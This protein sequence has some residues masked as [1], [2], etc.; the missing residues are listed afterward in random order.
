LSAESTK[1]SRELDSDVDSLQSNS[2]RKVSSLQKQ[3]SR[4]KRNIEPAFDSDAD[5]DELPAENDDYVFSQVSSDPDFNGI[6]LERQEYDSLVNVGSDSETDRD[7]EP[8]SSFLKRLERTQTAIL[9]KRAERRTPLAIQRAQ[10]RSLL[11]SGVIDPLSNMREHWESYVDNI[12]KDF[13]KSKEARLELSDRVTRGTAAYQ[14]L[15]LTQLNNGDMRKIYN[16]SWKSKADLGQ[17]LGTYHQ[18]RIVVGQYA[19]F[20]VAAKLCSAHDLY[21]KGALCD[22]LC[23]LP[24][25]QAFIRYFEIRSAAGTVMNKAFHLIRLC[26]FAESHFSESGRSEKKGNIVS[27]MTYLQTVAKAFKTESRRQAS[28][29]K[30]SDMRV[31]SGMYLTENDITLYANNA[32]DIL[33]D[34][35]ESCRSVYAEKGAEGVTGMMT[36]TNKM[37][38][39][40]CINFLSALTLHGGGQRPQVYT[41]LEA[42]SKMDFVDMRESVKS[43]GVFSIRVSFEKRVRCVDLPQVLFLMRRTPVAGVFCFTPNQALRWSHDK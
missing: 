38:N 28:I 27:V 26:K 16:I 37:L 7:D 6:Q 20:S 34:M 1:H 8:K 36:S 22:I 17:P 3:Q 23:N 35:L 10:R 31:G 9:A 15:I 42:P 12:S 14:G 21:R 33:N 40:W 24:A 32:L 13:F 2:E 39:K 4:F 18:F 25:V 43:T 41:M 29:R 19:R 5:D 30:E 11:G